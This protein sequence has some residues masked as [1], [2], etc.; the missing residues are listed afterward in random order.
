MTK[1]AL[2][3]NQDK[4][5]CITT[6]GAPS[7]LGAT[8]C[9]EGV[10][11]SVFSKHATGV[12]LLLFNDVDDISAKYIIHLNPSTSRTYHYWH[13]FVHGLMAGQLYA[14]RVY[15]PF[16]PSSGLRFDPT[17]VVLDPYGR[18]VAVPT[19]YIRAAACQPGDN[20]AQAMKSV[21]VDPSLYDWESDT[22]LRRTSAQTVVYEAHVRDFTYHPSSG[23]SENN[24]GTFAGLSEKIPYLKK[25]RITAVELL[26]VF[27]YDPQDSPPG[28]T[29][30][31]GYSPV[32][33]FA[34]HQ[35]YSS[36]ED[37][38]GVIDEFR[39][40]VKALHAA[41]I[42]V[43]LDVV[44]NHTAEGDQNGPTLSFRGFDNSVYYTI[45]EDGSF[46]NY[47][48]TGNTLNANHPIVRRLILDSLRYWVQEMHV[49]GF[50]FDLASVLARDE[51]GLPLSSPPVLWD[52]ESDPVLAGTKL[53]AEAWDA[54]GLYQVGNFVGDSWREWN[55]RF[56]DDVRA[57]FR[58]EVGS[59]ARIADRLVG[60]PALYEHKGREAEQSVNFVTCHDGFTLND[61]VSFNGKHNEANGEDN[62]D[63]ADDNRSWNCGFEGPTSD[64]LID[65]LRNQQ[66]K[67]FLTVTMVS[68]GIPMITMGDEVRRTQF[69]NNNAYCQDN[70]TSWFNWS[71]VHK[72]ADVLRFT[73]LLVA[74]RVL[75]SIDHE[76]Q[77]ISLGQLIQK[78]NKTWHGT[79]LYCPDWG[80]R[81]HSFALEA[82]LRREKIK[83]YLLL[84]AFW[85]PLV[86]ELPPTGSTD[87]AVWCRWID[88]SMQSPDDIVPWLEAPS[89]SGSTYE[90]SAHSVVVL[91]RSLL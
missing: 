13:T 54:A 19:N 77:R 69:G 50:R 22:P 14:Y 86:F 8:C 34:L 21:V 3:N 40:M 39:D 9:P 65:K 82:E 73:T 56:R 84:N 43:I 52:I 7:P 57:F 85:E 44:F 88:T 38:L 78:S 41:G 18:C 25:L 91:I 15:G 74:R 37:C 36:R 33:F 67:N 46:A 62:R 16:E 72:H 48:G 70:E 60:S 10:N 87:G 1:I 63:G 27:Q 12:D 28:K 68:L 35:L 75:R 17:K 2:M 47:T 55:G 31:W 5:C 26:P 53:I 80:A 71:L 4:L 45:G 23:V 90:A 76:M 79:K 51:T 61:L 81:S 66:I 32:S 30:Y 20:A 11:F 64:P 6:K 59:A 42:E 29:N 49:D 89:V 58:C 24:R 83:F